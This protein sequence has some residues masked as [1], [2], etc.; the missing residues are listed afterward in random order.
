MIINE[1]VITGKVNLK[2]LDKRIKSEVDK[3]LYID[4]KSNQNEIWINYSNTIS[5]SGTIQFSGRMSSQL[6]K[7]LKEYGFKWKGLYANDY[8]EVYKRV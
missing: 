4:S 3:R 6:G 1:S 5:K 8:C 2:E 7:I